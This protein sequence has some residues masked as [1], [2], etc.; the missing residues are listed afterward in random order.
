MAEPFRRGQREPEAARFCRCGARL[1]RD[2]PGRLCAACAKQ[3]QQARLEPPKVP[4]EVWQA[5]PLKAV[6]RSGL[7]GALAGE[8]EPQMFGWDS[9]GARAE[10]EPVQVAHRRPGLDAAELRLRDPQPS[11]DKLLRE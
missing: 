8:V 7:V 1:A 10:D 6:P 11:R 5:E 9:Q 2:N 3:D 4:P